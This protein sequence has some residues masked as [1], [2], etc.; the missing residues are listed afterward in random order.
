MKKPSLIVPVILSGGS[1]TR[2]WPMSRPAQPKQFLPL[3]GRKTLFQET[4]GRVS[5]KGYGAPII[6]CNQEHR[7]LVAEQLREIGVRARAVILEPVGRNTAAAAA[8]AALAVAGKNGD[9]D[10][11]LLPSDHVIKKPKRF[12]EAVKRA[13]RASKAGALVTFGVAPDRPHTGYGYIRK[14]TR[15]P[16]TAGCFRVGRFVEKPNLARARAYLAGGDY[17]WNAGIFLF[18]ADTYLKELGRYAPGVLA[19]CR[20]AFNK[21]KKDL[22]FFRLDK[23][24]FERCPSGAID[25]LVME[26]TDRAA[27]VPVDMDWTDAGSW[28]TVWETGRK[29]AA[30]NVRVGNVKTHEVRGCYLHSDAL[31]LAAVGLDD[32]VVVATEDAVLVAPRARAEEVRRVAVLAEKDEAGA[33]FSAVTVHRPW[34]SYRTLKRGDRFQV[35]QIVVKPGAALSLQYHR[36]RAEHWVVVAGRARVWRNKEKFILEENQSTFIPVGARHRLEN[37]G[38]TPLLLIEVQSGDYLGEDDIVRLEDLYGRT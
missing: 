9:A 27:V 8:V 11:L 17:A 15:F 38:K 36:R 21:G 26:K 19:A 34:G 7:F 12:T 31:T 2:L 20:K 25:V 33:V 3:G 16:R 35:K 37:I 13:Q 23:K 29:D 22:D 14:G 4:I 18:K 1:G 28:V 10:I 30:G 32:M 6:I 24:A 5:G